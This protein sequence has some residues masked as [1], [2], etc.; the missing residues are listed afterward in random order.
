MRSSALLIALLSTSSCSAQTQNPAPSVDCRFLHTA[1]AQPIF[2]GEPSPVSAQLLDDRI[3]IQ[4]SNISQCEITSS[5]FPVD[6]VWLYPFSK[7]MLIYIEQSALGTKLNLID[8]K[9]CL[10]LKS[11]ETGKDFGVDEKSVW[12]YTENC[13]DDKSKCVRKALF[14][15][16]SACNLE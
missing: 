10:V 15:F 12:T 7:N 1:E 5:G 3:V 14:K 9:K 13:G 11:Q 16:N 4:G 6:L 2:N 8:F